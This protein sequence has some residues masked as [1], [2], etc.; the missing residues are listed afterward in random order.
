MNI[1]QRLSDFLRDGDAETMGDIGHYAVNQILLRTSQGKDYKNNSFTPYSKSYKKTRQKAGLPTAKVD[2]F[3]TGKML[4]SLSYRGETSKDI[5]LFFADREQS[6]KALFNNR[7]REFFNI[8]D[9]EL[10]EIRMII[11]KKIVDKIN[12]L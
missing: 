1:L 9:A 11:V 2:L 10:I 7:K 3:F 5:K 4:G 6:M 12:G 8:N